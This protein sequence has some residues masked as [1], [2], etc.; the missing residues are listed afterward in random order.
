MSCL[1]RCPRFGSARL[2]FLCSSNTSSLGMEARPERSSEA[3]DKRT[4]KLLQA[5][6]WPGNVRELQNVIERAVILI[7]SDCF[8]VDE[9]WLRQ[10]RSEVSRPTVALTGVLLNQEKEMIET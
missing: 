9:T 7:D 5:Y 8:A 3:I 6:E 2:M 1:F 4:L 10:D